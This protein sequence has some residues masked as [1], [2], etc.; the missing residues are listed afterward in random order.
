MAI[1]ARPTGVG[2]GDVEAVAGL[3]LPTNLCDP[4]AKTSNILQSAR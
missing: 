4:G 2:G 3:V 1:D